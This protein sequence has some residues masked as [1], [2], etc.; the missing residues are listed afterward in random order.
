[1]WQFRHKFTDCVCDHT[2]SRTPLFIFATWPNWPHWSGRG[3]GKKSELSSS[4]AAYSD[5][6]IR[7]T[8]REIPRARVRARAHTLTHT[9]RHTRG[10][11]VVPL[12]F[13]CWKAHLSLSSTI[14]DISLASANRCDSLCCKYSLSKVC[15]M[16]RQ[17]RRKLNRFMHCLFVLL[18]IQ[19]PDEVP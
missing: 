18:I 11:P 12:L 17:L 2:N 8:C 16:Q 10:R 19:K 1:M 6:D 3:S 13:S 9:H 14:V 5:E 15:W 4:G 7:A